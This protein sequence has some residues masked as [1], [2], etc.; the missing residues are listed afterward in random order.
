[1]RAALADRRPLA[2]PAFRRWWA[3]S[4]VTAVGGS[5]SVVAVPA[6]LYAT[7]GTSA[8]LGGSAILS[9]AGLVIGAL[10]AGTMADRWDRRL[11]LLVAQSGLAATYAGLWAQASLNGPLPILLTLITCQGLTFGAISTTAGAVLPRLLPSELLAAANSL[12]S[13]VRYAGWILGPILGGLLIPAAGL[14]TLYLCDAAALAA[15]LWA[16]LQLPPMPPTTQTPQKASPAQAPWRSAA[17]QVAREAPVVGE[18]R[19]GPV[20]LEPLPGSAARADRSGRDGRGLR[21]GLRH[22]RTSRLLMAVLAVDLAAMV[23]GMPV[24]LFPEL[25]RNTYGDPVG[26][27]PVLGLFYAAYPAGVIVAGLL[28]G[29]FTRVRR[30]GRTMAFAAM[31]W[32][33]TV[34][35]LGLTTHLWVAL[36]ALVLGGAVNFVLSTHRNAITQAHTDDALLGRVQGLLT[37]VLTGGPQLANLLHGAAGALIGPRPAIIAG[38]LLTA[39]AVAVTL[40]ATPELSAVEQTKQPLT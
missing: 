26:G 29:T 14:S 28:S 20:A 15:V 13:L 37:V 23:L 3:A 4:L 30:P 34:V 40:R 19:E 31:A 12:N 1:V 16:V 5:F 27:G 7:T 35:L 25:A 33:A 39:T 9:L 24:V 38:G 10:T 2:V 11:V 6:Q 17:V 32:G 8:A 22:L 18:P 21:G 36:A